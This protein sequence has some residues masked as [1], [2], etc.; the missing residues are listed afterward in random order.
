MKKGLYT[1]T[2]F[3]M[4]LTLVGCGADKDKGS[5][6]DSK[7]AKTTT[8]SDEKK[9]SKKSDK[10]DDDIKLDTSAPDIKEYAGEYKKN[11]H[12]LWGDYPDEL[13]PKALEETLKNDPMTISEDGILHF[14]GKD[15]KLIPEGTK[16]GSHI[17]SVEGSTFDFKSFCKPAKGVFSTPKCVDKDY[18]GIVY[19]V[20]EEM[21]MTVN[22][23]DVP[24]NDFKIYL[25]AKGDETCSEYISFD[26]KGDDDDDDWSFDWDDED[27]DNIKITFGD[28]D[29]EE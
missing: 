5:D 21:H 15:Y 10:S 19:F 17:Y 8:A 20:D 1:F 6:K 29:T 26:L 22:D 4:A 25:T 18:E 24:Y 23:E 3:M 9:D 11:G 13:D 2:A 14:C 12:G 27:D 16:E 7:S 28:E